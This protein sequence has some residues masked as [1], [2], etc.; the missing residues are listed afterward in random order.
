MNADRVEVLPDEVA[1]VP[2]QP[3]RLAVADRLQRAHASSSSR[4]RSRSGAPR[5]RTA[6]RPRRTRRGSGSSGRR[7]PGSRRRSSTAGTGG[8]IATVLPDRRPGE[9]DDRASRRARPRPARCPSSPRPPAAARPRARRRPRPGRAGSPR[10]RSSIG[11]SQTACPVRW[12]EIA[13]TCRPCLLQDLAAAA[14]RRRRP[15]RAA[16]GRSGRPSRRSRARRS[17]TRPRAGDL[18]ERQVGPLAGEQRDRSCHAAPPRRFDVPAAR[19][20]PT[21]STA[22]STRCTCSPSAN[23]GAG[24][25]PAAMRVTRS[26]TWWVNECS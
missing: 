1:R 13:Q 18:L 10:C 12:L 22:S 17:P 4:R 8:N 16:H 24:S 15:R 5:A 9:A 14:R 25:R 6:R 21:R 11:S 3:E 2:V 26:T 20:R 19:R 7:S 23:D